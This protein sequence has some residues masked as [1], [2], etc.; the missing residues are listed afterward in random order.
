MLS[1]RSIQ[2]LDG[3]DLNWEK[4]YPALPQC[5]LF[6]DQVWTYTKKDLYILLWVLK[7]AQ[8]YS[9]GAQFAL[10]MHLAHMVRFSTIDKL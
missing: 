1:A 2:V 8:K 9:N 3:G 7:E 10:D 6:C 5:P 4:P